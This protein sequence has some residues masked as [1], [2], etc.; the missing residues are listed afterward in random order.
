MGSLTVSH[1]HTLTSTLHFAFAAVSVGNHKSQ[2]EV[3]GK[4]ATCSDIIIFFETATQLDVL[5]EVLTI[6]SLSAM[7]Q[8]P[9]CTAPM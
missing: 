3:E 8:E 6:F 4:I 9:Y 5:H 7:C 2:V 1:I